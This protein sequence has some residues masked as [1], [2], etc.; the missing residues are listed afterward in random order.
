MTL[1]DSDELKRARKL[2][3]QVSAEKVDPTNHELLDE[4]VAR[5]LWSG[6]G[7]PGDRMVGLVC[8]ALGAMAALDALATGMPAHELARAISVAAGDEDN[9]NAE[10]NAEDVAEALARWLPRLRGAD[11]VGHLERAQRIGAS[12]LVPSN[13]LWPEGLARLG[14]HA[15]VALWL[16]GSVQVL[17]TLGK[18]LSIVGARAST[19]YGEHV[20]MDVVT[21]LVDRGFSIVSG[22]AYGI[23]GMAHRAALSSQGATMAVLAGGIDRLYP[24]GHDALLKRIIDA[25]L[26][27][28]ELPCGFAPTKWRFLQ[29]NR[30]IAALTCATVV[31]EA[32]WRSGSLNTAHHALDMD[33]P[34]GAIPGP[35]TSA[36]S[37]GS[38]RLLRETPAVCVTNAT[39]IA[40]LVSSDCDEPLSPELV[41][42]NA[43]RLLDSLSRTRARTHEEIVELSGLTSMQV[44]ATLGLLELQGSVRQNATGWLRA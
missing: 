1:L 22:A 33:I 10:D 35:V 21:A 23:D 9:D 18:S 7:E 39:D 27:I 17:S 32:G 34:V 6:I 29:R 12:V 14:D 40:Q 44:M 31:V 30:L 28:T 13:A 42:P 37:A 41:H 36:S 20:T 43:T 11:A 8:N 15:P 24:S 19:G 38:H 16:R 26:V 3:H 2:A 5:S 25:G 4:I